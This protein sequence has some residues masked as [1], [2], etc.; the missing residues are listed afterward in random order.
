LREGRLGEEKH[1]CDR[2]GADKPSLQLSDRDPSTSD[3]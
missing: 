2:E 3:D 1:M